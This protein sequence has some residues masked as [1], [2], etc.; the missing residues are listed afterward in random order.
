[1]IEYYRRTLPRGMWWVRIRIG[2]LKVSFPIFIKRRR[3]EVYK[4]Q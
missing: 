4:S 3:N 1:M 2:G